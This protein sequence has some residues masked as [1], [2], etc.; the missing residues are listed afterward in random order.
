M[1]EA[2]RAG[3]NRFVTYRPE[4]DQQSQQNL[5]LLNGFR[6]I[7]DETSIEIAFQPIVA[8]ASGRIVAVEALA[9][10]PEHIQ[11]HF[12]PD[13]FIQ[14]AETHG[15]IGALGDTILRKTCEWAKNWQGVRISYNLSPVQ[16]RDPNFVDRALTIITDYGLS[17]HS[18]EFEVTESILVHDIE[19]VQQQLKALRA[20]G[21]QIALDDFGSGY[22][23][24]GYMQKLTFDRIKIDRSIIA[25]IGYSA[26]NQGIA[27]G[28][29]TMARG[30]GAVVTAE[31]IESAEQASLLRLAGCSELQGYYFHKPMPASAVSVLLE[32]QGTRAIERSA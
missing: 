24:V 31:G 2:K 26:V 28:T 9:R 4:M 23:S 15:M 19:L 25:N 10:W 18:F 21:I 1:Y 32:A 11:P 6:Q 8:A 14:F 20:S 30:M 22:S 12:T 17:P 13:K 27:M 29:V 7:I 16:L 5:A 3:K